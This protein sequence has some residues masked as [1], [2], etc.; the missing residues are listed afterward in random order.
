MG[1]TYRSK[2]TSRPRYYCTSARTRTDIRKNQARTAQSELEQ[3]ARR[4]VHNRGKGK[5]RQDR[6][7]RE[8]SPSARLLACSP[9]EVPNL[10]RSRAQ[11]GARENNQGLT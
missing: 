4:M 7:S 11:S 2:A 1:A 3:L 5:H 8:R 9:K 6:G 10:G